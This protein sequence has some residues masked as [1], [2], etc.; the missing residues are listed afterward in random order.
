MA[1]LWVAFGGTRA[2]GPDDEL[3]AQSGVPIQARN[4]PFSAFSS[5]QVGIHGILAILTASFLTYTAAQSDDR[6]GGYLAVLVAL[7]ATAVPGLLMFRK[8]RSRRRPVVQAVSAST[9][10]PR[11]EDRIPK[12][13][14]YLHGAAAAATVIVVLVLLILD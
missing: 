11:V 3:M 10:E 13:V 12:A 6:S 5:A 7:A 4:R 8:W 9:R 1:I 2:V 14:V